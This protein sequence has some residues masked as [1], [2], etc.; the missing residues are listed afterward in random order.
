MLPDRKRQVR[1]HA[2]FAG[3]VEVKVRPGQTVY[4]G[5]ALVVVEGDKQIE[6]LSALASGTVISVEV[7]DGAEVAAAA[8]L[9]VLQQ[10]DRV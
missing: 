3:A 5:M 9:V 8:L 4:R 1:V 6:I 7:E 10:A 2:N